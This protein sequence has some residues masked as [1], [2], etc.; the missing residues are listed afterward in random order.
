MVR[1]IVRKRC[2][3]KNSTSLCGRCVRGGEGVRDEDRNSKQPVILLRIAHS[4]L[5]KSVFKYCETQRSRS[6]GQP[7]ATWLS[8]FTQVHDL[9]LTIVANVPCCTV[10]QY[11]NIGL[12][13]DSTLKRRLQ[14]HA[15]T[16][17]RSCERRQ[18]RLFGCTLTITNINHIH[19]GGC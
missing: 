13:S 12:L 10:G 6:H 11:T 18:K 7:T 9:L 2:R 4:Y 15:Y 5:T 1:N 8:C 14:L 16:S 19:N 3:Q 17:T